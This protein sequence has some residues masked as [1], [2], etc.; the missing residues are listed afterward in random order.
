MNASKIYLPAKI[1]NLLGNVFTYLLGSLSDFI[2]YTNFNKLAFFNFFPNVALVEDVSFARCVHVHDS[3]LD[4]VK[5]TMN[6]Q[7]YPGLDFCLPFI[8]L[9]VIKFFDIHFVT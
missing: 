3:S 7:N 9:A 2:I 6:H 5:K 4:D 1:G 8:V